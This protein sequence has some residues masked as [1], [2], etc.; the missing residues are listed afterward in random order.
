MAQIFELFTSSFKGDKQSTRPPYLLHAPSFHCSDSF[1]G[2]SHYEESMYKWKISS[3]MS[4]LRKY[5]N[6]CFYKNCKHA[7]ECQ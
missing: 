1:P 2:G 7:Q 5:R 3:E 6:I 4:R